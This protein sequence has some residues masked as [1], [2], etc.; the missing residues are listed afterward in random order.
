MKVIKK[1]ENGEY[2]NRVL[3]MAA[4]IKFLFYMSFVPSIYLIGSFIKCSI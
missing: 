1:I 2:N 4:I 3:F